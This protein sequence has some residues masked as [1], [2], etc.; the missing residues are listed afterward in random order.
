MTLFLRTLILGHF[1]LQYGDGLTGPI[2]IHGPSSSNWDTDIGTV[3]INDWYHES[4]F[5]LFSIEQT[6]GPA[7]AGAT[8]GL[9]N[10]MNKYNGAG[11]YYNMSFTSGNKH[12]IRLINSSVD[13]HFKVMIDDH[14]MTVLLSFSTLISGHGS[15]LCSYHTIFDPGSE[16]WNWYCALSSLLH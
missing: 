4:A 5:K 7:A 11:Q 6:R 16:H 12:R 3:M 14:N 8:T 15:R 13:T 2:L 1:S 9:V 10:G